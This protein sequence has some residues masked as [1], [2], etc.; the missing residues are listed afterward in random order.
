MMA[1][2]TFSLSGAAPN[3]SMAVPSS[4]SFGLFSAGFAAADESAPN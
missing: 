1:S 3:G 4:P 2:V